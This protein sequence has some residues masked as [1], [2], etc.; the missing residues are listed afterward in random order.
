MILIAYPTDEY[1]VLSG[2]SKATFDIVGIAALWV[3]EFGCRGAHPND[4][5]WA[6]QLIARITSAVRAVSWVDWRTSDTDYGFW[7][8]TTQ[9]G[10][11]LVDAGRALSY[12]TDLG[13]DGREF[14]LNDTAHFTR[15]HSVAI[16]NRG[17]K[18]VTSKS[19]LQEAEGYAR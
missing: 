9:V 8:P 6:R 13:F 14:G 12:K 15:T 19:S 16:F 18:P 1:P 7:A 11:G 4:P 10:G 3:G 17:L 2:T 5:E